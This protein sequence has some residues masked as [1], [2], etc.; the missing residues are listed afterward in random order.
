MYPEAT[1]S[2]QR[3]PCTVHLIRRSLAYA[4]YQE[5]RE[6]A[7]ALKTVYRVPTQAAAEAT[8]DA[9]E[10]SPWGQYPAVAGSQRSAREHVTLFFAFLQ[11]IR[12]A[13]CTT[14]AI[15]D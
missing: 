4:S 14:N 10:S 11:P 12:R 15:E 8:L 13:I 7:D 9:F 2:T 1:A 3:V 5:R 6:L